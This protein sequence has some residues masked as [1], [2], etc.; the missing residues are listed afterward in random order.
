MAH[1]LVVTQTSQLHLDFIRAIVGVNALY[2]HLAFKPLRFICIKA[3][4]QRKDLLRRPL[5]LQG[6]L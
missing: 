6:D 4:I 3:T 1:P 5:V 2:F